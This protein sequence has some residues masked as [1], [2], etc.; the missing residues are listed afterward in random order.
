MIPDNYH[1]LQINLFKTNLT[2][3]EVT[4]S[5][6]ARQLLGFGHNLCHLELSLNTSVS[7]TERKVKQN[8]F[9]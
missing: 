7:K 4:L 8:S 9:S 6:M 2:D 3:S 5:C 1:F